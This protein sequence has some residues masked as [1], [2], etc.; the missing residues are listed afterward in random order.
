MAL[1]RTPPPPSSEG[2]ERGKNF[3]FFQYV[4]MAGDKNVGGI[5]LRGALGKLW[6]DDLYQSLQVKRW[7][8]STASLCLIDPD[9]STP[10]TVDQLIAP[11]MPLPR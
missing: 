6:A 4:I 8:H 11:S 7:R 2:I 10:W 9:Q 1:W 3:V 5:A